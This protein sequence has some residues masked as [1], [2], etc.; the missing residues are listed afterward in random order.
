MPNL[1]NDF[2]LKWNV[3]ISGHSETDFFKQKICNFVLS[4]VFIVHICIACTCIHSIIIKQ[5]LFHP[6]PNNKD[7][8]SFTYLNN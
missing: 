3:A 1:A 2:D 6:S 8:H 7:M 4:V 5:M